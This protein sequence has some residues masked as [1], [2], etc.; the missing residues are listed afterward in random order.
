MESVNEDQECM[1]CVCVCILIIALL[2][3]IRCLLL[4]ILLI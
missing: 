4:T 1:V 2:Y 3:T